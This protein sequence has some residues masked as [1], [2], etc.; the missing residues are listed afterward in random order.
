[1]NCVNSPYNDK[2]FPQTVQFFAHSMKFGRINDPPD[3]C[4]MKL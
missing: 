3:T 2:N 1:M 4:V